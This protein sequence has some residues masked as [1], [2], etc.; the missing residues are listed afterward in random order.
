MIELHTLHRRPPFC[1][2]RVSPSGKWL[3]IQ[4]WLHR[5]GVISLSVMPG[6]NNMLYKYYRICS[7]MPAEFVTLRWQ[8]V[9]PF[10]RRP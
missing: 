7:V 2:Y 6:Y 10:T 3:R 5:F 9:Q 1:D 8:V 4:M